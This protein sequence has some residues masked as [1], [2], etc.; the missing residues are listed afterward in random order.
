MTQLIPAFSNLGGQATFALVDISTYELSDKLRAK[1]SEDKTARRAWIRR[2]DTDWICYCA[3]TGREESVRISAEN[4]ATTIYGLIADYDAQPL[5]SEISTCVV[6]KKRFKHQ[7][8]FVERTLSGNVRVCWLL[9]KPLV[10]SESMIALFYSELASEL[11]LDKCFAG[12][13]K[14][15]KNIGQLHTYSGVCD[16]MTFDTLSHQLVSDIYDRCVKKSVKVSEASKVRMTLDIV[17]KEIRRRCA[18][19]ATD[20]KYF[21]GG[22][23]LPEKF[24]VGAR[25]T[26]FWAA[27]ADARS[28]IILDRGLQ[29]YSGPN[30]G[31]LSYEMLLGD[32]ILK[33]EA[34]S[35]ISAKAEGIYFDGR[36]YYHKVKDVWEQDS[37]SDI[38]DYIA[39]THKI[40]KKAEKGELSQT[41]QV[42]LHIREHNR[43][44]YAAPLIY[45]DP[46][47]VYVDSERVLNTTRTYAIPPASES[48]NWAS[49]RI[50]NIRR[51]L[52]S[53]IKHDNSDCP[54]N[55][56]TGLKNRQL[57]HLL[58]WTSY[59]YK[60]AYKRKPNRGQALI[61]A[62]ERDSGKGLFGSLI[63][64][65]LLGG[66][67]EA[68]EWLEGR[69]KY[70]GRLLDKAVWL[71][72]DIDV[73]DRA[74][75]AGV[76]KKSVSNQLMSFEE[77]YVKSG[78][79]EWRGR[80]VITTNL[81]TS[82]IM[83]LPDSAESLLDKL[84]VI[85][86]SRGDD[87]C[88]AESEQETRKIYTSEL[89]YFARFLL[90]YK[91]NVSSSKKY[92]V[93]HYYNQTLLEV[94]RTQDEAYV[95]ESTIQALAAAR[96]ING[97]A[98][99]TVAD[100]AS[101]IEGGLGLKSYGMTVGKL[102]R[103]LSKLSE[104]CSWLDQRF[105]RAYDSNGKMTRYY[106][107]TV[108]T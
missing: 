4:P 96:Q 62:G 80:I 38:E 14:A 106:Q 27:D 47:E 90:D 89:Q 86:T 72:D 58:A 8:A 65:K 75:L 40:S 15:Y 44:D 5:A 32:E 70:N 73:R 6:D 37:A 67:G 99:L 63:L 23:T 41:R 17:E 7:P 84:I 102:A 87:E 69:T 77:K 74:T 35:Y 28:V 31:F 21:P 10:S 59:A 105:D 108:L 16:Y 94:S 3:A 20:P 19:P 33:K 85:R 98:N 104:S 61:L 39:S 60:C 11:A 1:Y 92:G 82:A 9:P 26:R 48:V 81:D 103:H 76:V 25:T 42:M 29:V 100:I 107:V 51:L 30:P 101:H 88:F 45:L 91:P 13:D 18:L 52:E 71:A 57:D 50:K 36:V 97:K 56:V 95:L 49:S 54:V 34:E 46:G 12:L 78:Q 79:S 22:T 93:T 68:N 43:V 66:A 2:N 24:E 55:E 53:L 64:A 83:A